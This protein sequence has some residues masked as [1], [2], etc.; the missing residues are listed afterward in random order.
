MYVWWLPGL[1]AKEYKQL[2]VSSDLLR[3]SIIPILAIVRAGGAAI[4][5][6]PQ[7]TIAFQM[8]FTVNMKVWDIAIIE[9]I[10][11]ASVTWTS[12]K[13][14]ALHGNRYIFWEFERQLFKED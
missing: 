5:E 10:S 6:H 1:K 11:C 3:V 4:L 7:S 2:I 8:F 14:V 12:V 9:A 13:R